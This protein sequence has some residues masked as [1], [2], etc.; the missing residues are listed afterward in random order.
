MRKSAP[1]PTG[2]PASERS[3]AVSLRDRASAII[4]FAIVLTL[5]Y[6]GRDVLIS[7]LH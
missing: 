7:L 1:N 4:A 6:L 2:R 5:L 3:A